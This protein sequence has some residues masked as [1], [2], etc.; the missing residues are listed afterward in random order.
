MRLQMETLGRSPGC[1][2]LWTKDEATSCNPTFIGHREGY[3]EWRVEVDD[4]AS[5]ESND[6]QRARTSKKISLDGKSPA[7]ITEDEHHSI[8]VRPGTKTNSDQDGAVDD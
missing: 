1:G 3:D 5:G 8:V 4:A 2:Q 7:S 6:T